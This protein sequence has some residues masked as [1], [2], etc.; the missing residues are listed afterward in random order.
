MI[1]TITTN[2]VFRVV[3]TRVDEGLISGSVFFV[4]DAIFD[5]IPYGIASAVE[6]AGRFGYAKGR[7]FSASTK[8]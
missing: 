4:G 8:P 1:A 7:T 6:T 3:Q 5:Y 2:D